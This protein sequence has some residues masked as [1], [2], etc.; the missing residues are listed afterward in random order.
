MAND[1][2]A[3]RQHLD[4]C[5]L[6]HRGPEWRYLDRVCNSCLLVLGD[7]N[8]PAAISSLSWSFDGKTIAANQNKETLRIWDADSGRERFTTTVKPNGFSKIAFS[9]NGGLVSIG[10]ME[11]T[12]RNVERKLDVRSWDLSTQQ[13][14]REFPVVQ[15]TDRFAI[16]GDARLLAVSRKGA[17][18]VYHVP[19][20][21]LF[22]S[23]RVSEGHEATR[24]WLDDGGQR[25][26]LLA[27]FRVVH[28]W[29]TRTKRFVG[30]VRTDNTSIPVLSRDGERLALVKWDATKS[31]I[32]EIWNLQDGK[33][34]SSARLGTQLITAA[35]FSPDGRLLATVGGD[36]AVKVWDVITGVE[37]FTFRGHTGPVSAVSFSPDGQRLASGAYDGTVR[38]WDVRP[39]E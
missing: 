38:I 14:I 13:V 3:T 31:G 17:V 23:L 26:A 8:A 19:S 15:L 29:D 32:V 7:S 20:G 16:S 35:D 9:R 11:P 33:M 10:T 24:L 39:L 34:I 6:P 22:G 25:I 5:P 37:H 21:R 12:P 1:L 4:E 18:S 36:S 27:D 30:S 28:V 2:A